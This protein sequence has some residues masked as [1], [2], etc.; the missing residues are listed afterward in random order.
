MKHPLGIAA[1]LYITGLLIADCLRLPLIPL[2]AVSIFVALAAIIV[3]P[4]RRILLWVLLVLVGCTNLACHKSIISPC[5]LRIILDGHHEDVMVRGI[6]AETPGTRTSTR[7][8]ARLT[9]TIAIVDVTELRRSGIWQPAFGRIVVDTRG[10]IG[11]GFFE[12]RPVEIAGIISLPPTPLADGLF[13]YRN[14]LRRQGIYFQLRSFSA[15]DWKLTPPHAT[16]PPLSNR[17]VTWAKSTLERGLAAED[18]S[19]RLLWA[20][21]LGWRDAL[22]G[23]VYEPFVESGT[24]HIFAI[25]GL[26]IALIAGILV[27]ILRVAQISR[28]WCGMVVIPLIWFYTAATG[29]QPSAIRS[30]I[31]MTIIVGGWALKRPSN[32]VNSLAAAALV[33]LLWE[34]Q[35]LFQAGFQLSFFVV[36]SIALVLPPL[37]KLRDRLLQP[38][39]FRPAE[40]MPRWQKV[41][42]PALRWLMTASAVSLAAWLGSWPLT[43]YYFHIFSPVTLLANVLIIP[44]ASAA[45]ASSLGS[46]F[47]GVWFPWASELFN[48]SAWFWMSCMTGVSR[49]AANLPVAFFHVSPPHP[50]DFA[51]YYTVLFATMSGALASRRMLPWAAAFAL[52]AGGFYFIRWM[53]NRQSTVVTAIP[54]DGGC[55]VYSDAP[56]RKDDLLINCGNT[57][58]VQRILKPWL[59]AQ[60]VNSLPGL[61]LTHGDLRHIGGTEPLCETFTV[62]EI[63]VPDVRFRSPTYRR[64]IQTTPGQS[65]QPRTVKRGDSISGWTVLHPMETDTFTQADDNAAVLM[66]DFYGT[67]ILL[68]SDLGRPGQNALLERETDLRAD[69]VIAGLPEQSEPLSDAL[70]DVVAPRVVIVTDSEFPATKRA[71][72][73]LAT[74]LQQRGVHLLFTRKTGAVTVRLTRNG[75][76]LKTAHGQLL[77]AATPHPQPQESLDDD[78][79]ADETEWPEER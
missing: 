12:G 60:G 11:P 15:S 42:R 17:F 53:D 58:P 21:T 22:P 8:S 27:A 61:L 46:L 47:F 66:G 67:R 64:L 40:L 43:A 18:E 37:E 26:H 20:M 71:N 62:R 14:H 49:W 28:F 45:L 74:R 59:K 52:L 29:W 36:F 3:S 72:A 1:L 73:R 33:I 55:A 77:D 50:V 65:G 30:T 56:G 75:W 31:M 48:Y 35:Q 24:M 6:L 16:E 57:N 69:V 32:L 2:F 34:P 70:L 10:E 7:Q 68:L 78:P 76:Q 79:D 5:D 4:A 54:L 13:N 25:S 19:L 38:D 9:R 41:F 63:L 51:V 39:P 23:D 44:L